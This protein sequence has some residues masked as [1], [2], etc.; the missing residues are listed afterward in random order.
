MKDEDCASIT[1]RE[2]VLRRP[3]LILQCQPRKGLSRESDTV[4]TRADDLRARR[5][6][7]MD[8]E[9]VNFNQLNFSVA[10][11]PPISL[12][13]VA[14]QTAVI[15]TALRPSDARASEPQIRRTFDH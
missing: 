6:H 3:C 1:V 9:R 13:R 15:A 11:N 5:V 8:R 14:R 7:H 2:D 12:E 4:G 10:R